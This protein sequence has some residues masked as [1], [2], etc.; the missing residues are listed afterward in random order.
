[1]KISANTF[2]KL[3]EVSEKSFYRWKSKDHKILINLID[4]YFNEDD[5]KEFIENG[6]INRL[7]N[8]DYKAS[9]EDFKKE[10]IDTIESAFDNLYLQTISRMSRLEEIDN[11]VVKSSKIVNK[12]KIKE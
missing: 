2:S 1:M 7:E 8:D 6:K 10:I 12:N 3:L 11:K 4:K 5:I 9:N